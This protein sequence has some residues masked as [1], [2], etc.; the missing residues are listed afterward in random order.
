LGTSRG[1]GGFCSVGRSTSGTSR[2][3]RRGGDAE[4]QAAIRRGIARLRTRLG[5]HYAAA[6]RPGVALGYYVRG[7]CET[8]DPMLLARAAALP[9][10]PPV[11]ERLKSALGR[12]RPGGSGPLTRSGSAA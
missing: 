5:W 6:G 11:R 3:R 4:T 7:F 2:E 9:F 8:R 10:P 12:R 1:L